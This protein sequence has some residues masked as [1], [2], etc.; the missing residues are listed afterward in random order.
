MSTENEFIPFNK[1]PRL[2]SLCTITEKIDGSNACI[3][4]DGTKVTAC[5]R[6]RRIATRDA[7]YD[8]WD[9]IL[10]KDDNYRFGAWV[11][12]NAEDL[13]TLG[14]G[15]H[16]GEWCG[17][18]IQRAYRAAGKYFYLF[19]SDPTPLPEH[20]NVRK[21]PVL[22]EGEFSA[23]VLDTIVRGLVSHGSVAFPGYM[24]P[25]GVVIDFKYGGKFK[26][27]IDKNVKANN[28]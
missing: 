5:S 16:F 12:E 3:E 22:F 15:R 1:I 24:Q 20:L 25:E 26:V 13:L 2:N 18:G 7:R 8:E 19:Y 28:E 21:V 9:Y 11:Q 23:G 14:D 4:I 6:T 17:L 10:K 27:I